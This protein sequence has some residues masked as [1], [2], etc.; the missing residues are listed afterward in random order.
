MENKN[1]WQIK[2][3]L[4]SLIYG[5]VATGATSLFWGG[6]GD[7]NLL[8]ALPIGIGVMIVNFIWVAYRESKK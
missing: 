7:G 2:A 4:S 3:L 8:R 1:N 6:F 5:V